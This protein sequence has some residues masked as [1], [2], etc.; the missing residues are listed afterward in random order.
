M[1][2]VFHKAQFWARYSSLFT[3]MI[4]HEANLFT[5]DTSFFSTITSPAISSSNLNGNLFKHKK[6]CFLE[7]KL[8]QVIQVVYRCFIRPHLDYGDVIYDQPNLSSLANKIESVKYNAA[9]VITGVI[10]GTYKEKILEELGFES[11]KD[12][13]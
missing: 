12:R 8:I 5:D 6:L 11:L 2:Q 13:K 4:C 3:L 10:R 7:R 9:F 1:E